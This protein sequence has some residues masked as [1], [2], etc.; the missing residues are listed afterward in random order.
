M[1]IGSEAYDELLKCMSMHSKFTVDSF[2]VS[3][4]KFNDPAL[5]GED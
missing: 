4:E 2:W 3:G 1:S 5:T